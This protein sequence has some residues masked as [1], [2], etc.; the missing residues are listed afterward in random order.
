MSQPEDNSQRKKYSKRHVFFFLGL[1]ILLAIVIY[2]SAQWVSDRFFAQP[3]VRGDAE[4]RHSLENRET[5]NVNG[6]TYRLR[7]NLTSILLMGVD[8]Y[9]DQEQTSTYRNGGQADFLRLVVID[10]DAKKLWQI[11]IDR[12]T[13]TPISILGVMG[14]ETGTRNERISLS[15]GFGDGKEQSCELT[16]KAVQN[17]L[18]GAPV[19][20]YM[21][22]NMDGISE[23]NDL[24]GGVTVTLEDDFS[25]IDPTMTKGKKLTLV[26]DQAE[27]FI[28]SRMSMNIGTNEARMKRQETYMNEAQ[29]VLRKKL[30]SDASAAGDMFD[31]LLP[32]LTTDMARGRLVNEAYAARD[33][34]WA[35][36]LTAEGRHS[37]DKDGFMQFEVNQKSLQNIVLTVFYEKAD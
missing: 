28:R 2:L 29:S 27:I 1:A 17:L 13:I 5:V 4:L 32:Y 36:I 35:D 15:H 10:N 16:R 20:F 11:A 30:T 33:Y 7:N 9:S 34:E 6:V 26:G 22:L 25:S 23:L 8:K 31:S 21:A 19:D 12:D 37:V 24:L 14:N 3:E 18:F